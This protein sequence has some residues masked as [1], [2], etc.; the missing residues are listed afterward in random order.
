MKIIFVNL[1]IRLNLG[2][3]WGFLPICLKLDK[4]DLLKRSVFI[5]SKAQDG[6]ITFNLYTQI[7]LLK[8]VSTYQIDPK[9]DIL[10]IFLILNVSALNRKIVKYFIENYCGKITDINYYYHGNDFHNENS[11]LID[12]YYYFNS[13]THELIWNKN[14]GLIRAKSPIY[15][16]IRNYF[17]IPNY[18]F[19]DLHRI[20]RVF[21]SLKIILDKE[22]EQLNSSKDF[23]KV[24]GII[25]QNYSLDLIKDDLLKLPSILELNFQAVLKSANNQ[26]NQIDTQ[27][28][29]ENFVK[30]SEDL[31]K[32]VKLGIK[33]L[34]EDCPKNELQFF[35]NEMDNFLKN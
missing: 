7:E 34:T 29:K 8:L 9:I 12:E 27:L 15:K 1:D 21:S 31:I 33:M 28:Y 5:Y 25:Y 14:D 26:D 2:E 16:E 3:S 11:S 22:I 24:L 23:Q 32:L 20:R 17:N 6:K 35:L 19:I 4:Q 10:P 30:L 13:Y 18:L